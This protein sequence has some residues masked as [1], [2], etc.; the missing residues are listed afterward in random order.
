MLPLQ[1]E[2]G[3]ALPVLAALVAAAGAILLGIGAAN[4][5]GV[6]AIVGGIVAGVGVIAH[7]LVRHVTIDYEFF[8]RTS[9]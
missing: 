4:D 7:E 9:K 1:R 8:R 3:H 2:S 5:S 6:L